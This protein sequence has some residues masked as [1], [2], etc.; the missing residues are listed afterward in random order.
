MPE[1]TVRSVLGGHT[2]VSW[3]CVIRTIV[4]LYFLSGSTHSG[5]YT[6]YIRDVDDLGTWTD[7]VCTHS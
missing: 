7:P 5:H 4:Q 3:R 6:A 1:L 2:Q